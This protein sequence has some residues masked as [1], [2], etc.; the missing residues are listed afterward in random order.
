MITNFERIT[1]ELTDEEYDIL[2]FL[3]NGFVTKDKD[4]AIMSHTIVKLMNEFIEHRKITGIKMTDARLRKMVNYIRS[5]GLLPLIATSIGYYVSY[6]KEEIDKQIL[7]MEERA[8]SI[9]KAAEGMKK[10]SKQKK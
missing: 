7:S 9:I 3:I 1:N 5:N 6:D 10:F 4:H 2:P 8:R